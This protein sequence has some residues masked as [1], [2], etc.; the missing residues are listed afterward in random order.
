LGLGKNNLNG[1]L[2]PSL[3]DWTALR[4]LDLRSNLAVFDVVSNNFTGTIPRSIYT[5]RSMEALRVANNHMGGQVAPEIGDLHQLLFL[6]LT[7]ISF[8][9]R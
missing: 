6:S 1:T 9:N 8:T 2:P 7:I 5:C 3:S 4:C